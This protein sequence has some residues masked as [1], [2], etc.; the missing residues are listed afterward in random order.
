[1]IGVALIILTISVMH[2]TVYSKIVKEHYK[3]LKSLNK[4]TD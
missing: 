1:M 3:K 4:Y 2:C